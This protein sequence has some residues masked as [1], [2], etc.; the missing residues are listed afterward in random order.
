MPPNNSCVGARSLIFVWWHISL[1]VCKSVCQP[2][3]SACRWID[4]AQTA[5]QVTAQVLRFTWLIQFQCCMCLKGR[6]ETFVSWLRYLNLR[7]WQSILNICQHF[8]MFTERPF[9]IP[10]G[11]M[12]H[13]SCFEYSVCHCTLY[14]K[15]SP[16]LSNTV[17]Q[18]HTLPW[19][20]VIIINV[21]YV[22]KSVKD[23]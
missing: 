15:G 8:Q 12:W 23:T 2:K 14:S 9:D 4:W 1:Q 17:K 11:E 19:S 20:A 22:P 7:V 10:L 18:L 13:G 3:W 16:P 5:L 6:K 21:Y